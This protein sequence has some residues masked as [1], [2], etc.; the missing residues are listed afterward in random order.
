MMAMKEEGANVGAISKYDV[1]ILD[2]SISLYYTVVITF[3]CDVNDI[4]EPQLRESHTSYM[5][6]GYG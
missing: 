5:K 2:A 3:K 6:W 1:Y 4:R